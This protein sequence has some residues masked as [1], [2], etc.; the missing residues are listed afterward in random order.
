MKKTVKFSISLLMST[1]LIFTACSSSDN[2]SLINNSLNSLFDNNKS[3]SAD[4]T[5]GETSTDTT[6]NANLISDI[7]DN[8]DFEQYLNDFFCNY[9]TSDTITLHFTLKDPAAYGITDYPVTL[10][11]FT[12]DD[13]ENSSTYESDINELTK[14]DYNTL[15]NR[16]KLT[17]DILSY[18]YELSK[19]ADSIF[20]TVFKCVS[21]LEDRK[22]SM[23]QLFPM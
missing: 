12:L 10:G 20:R 14:F 19:E 23:A 22:S 16:E 3:D 18:T 2:N 5:T 15:S 8:S 4:A 6:D 11:S 7:P 1:C 13:I 17:Y 21:P 9:V